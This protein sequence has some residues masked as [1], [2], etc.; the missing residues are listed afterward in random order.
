MTRK[1]TDVH[2]MNSV[3]VEAP[4]SIGILLN[5]IC[6]LHCKTCYLENMTEKNPLSQ[7]EWKYVFLSMFNDLRPNTV[8]FVGKEVFAE[9]ESVDVMFYALEIRDKYQKSGETEIGVI[10]NGTLLHKYRKRL[11]GSSLD[12]IDISIDGPREVND[13]IRGQGSYS[14]L[15]RNLGWV[16][17][18]FEDRLWIT[19]TLCNSNASSMADLVGELNKEYGISRFSFGLYKSRKSAQDFF[20][21][22]TE[23]V[24]ILVENLS[25]IETT[26]PITVIFDYVGDVGDPY[27]SILDL[28]LPKGETVTVKESFLGNGVQLGVHRNNREVGLWRAIRVS[29]EGD[30]LAAEDLFDH[31][32][33]K[34]NAVSNLR[35]VNYDTRKAYEIGLQSPR[36]KSLGFVQL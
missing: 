27:S 19:P 14:K 2:S 34:E 33:Y 36:S 29:T 35:D 26:S 8:S 25:R 13:G 20:S 5:G 7:E 30:W 11:E 1:K 22:G 12:W 17:E 18:Y 6:N 24:K 31:L 28:P 21:V 3:F 10:T 9:R 15:E 4:T 23:E 16:S 32:C